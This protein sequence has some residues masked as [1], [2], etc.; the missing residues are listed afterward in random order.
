MNNDDRSIIY[1]VFT[2]SK[3]SFLEG[4]QTGHGSAYLHFPSVP[5]SLRIRGHKRMKEI[6]VYDANEG[7]CA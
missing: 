2:E 1:C 4:C 5:F 7:P 6:K 3:D